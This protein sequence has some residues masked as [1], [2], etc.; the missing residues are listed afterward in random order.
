[1]KSPMTFQYNRS[2]RY[3]VARY[4]DKIGRLGPPAFGNTKERAAFELGVLVA[5]TPLAFTRT[6]EELT[7][8]ET[9]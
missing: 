3:W 5:L 4:F 2:G 7:K 6:I 9:V 1:M 8:G